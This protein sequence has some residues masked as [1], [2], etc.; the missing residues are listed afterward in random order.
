VCLIVDFLNFQAIDISATTKTP[1]VRV[2]ESKVS[3]GLLLLEFS[4]HSSV[5]SHVERPINGKSM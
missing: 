3:F 4:L 2:C 5:G 1:Q